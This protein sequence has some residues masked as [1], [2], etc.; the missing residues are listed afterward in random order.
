MYIKAHKGLLHNV[1]WYQTV[2]KLEKLPD[3]AWCTFKYRLYDETEAYTEI[4]NHHGNLCIGVLS[5]KREGIYSGFQGDINL[6]I[7]RTFHRIRY[8]YYT[9]L[10][11]CLST[12]EKYCSRVLEA[13][14]SRQ[15]CR[16]R[17][18]TKILKQRVVW[19]TRTVIAPSLC[20]F[21]VVV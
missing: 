7:N 20:Y 3:A 12:T 14:R 16:Y 9:S 18:P 6:R 19:M 8:L 2:P 1:L 5:A 15:D 4:Y 13:Y 17:R 10:S 11:V 21:S